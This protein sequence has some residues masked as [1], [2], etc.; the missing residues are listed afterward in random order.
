MSDLERE[1]VALSGE[2]GSSQGRKILLCTESALS[3]HCVNVASDVNTVEVEGRTRD[4]PTMTQ[5]N[6]KA[7]ETI[8]KA[9]AKASSPRRAPFRYAASGRP[10]N[11][12]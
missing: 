10:R 2:R 8:S 11:M 6:K 7:H 12:S 1:E 9:A 5:S 4:K 3:F